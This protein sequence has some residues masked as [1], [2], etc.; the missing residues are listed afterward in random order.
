[1]I[2]VAFA[3]KLEDGGP[4]FFVQPRIGHDNRIFNMLKFRS[5]DAE[6]L[7]FEGNVSTRRNDTRVTKIGRLIRAT[8]L[9]ELPQ[10]INVLMGEMSLVGPRPHAL[11]HAPA[12]SF[13]GR[14]TVITGSV[15]H[16]RQA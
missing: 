1:M 13:S 9:D 12:T 5:M 16:S 11:G 2:L 14:S 3:I 8:S 7:D 15:M 4:V 6:A 10:I